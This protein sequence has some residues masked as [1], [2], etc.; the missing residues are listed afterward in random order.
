MA[1]CTSPS[2]SGLPRVSR[3][4]LPSS[5]V[6]LPDP[7]SR[8]AWDVVWQQ[9]SREALSQADCCFAGADLPVAPNSMTQTL[10]PSKHLR[11]SGEM[12][13]A[14]M[15]SLL[16]SAPYTYVTSYSSSLQ[17]QQSICVQRKGEDAVLCVLQ[18]K[19]RSCFCA[20]CCCL[21]LSMMC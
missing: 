6:V 8:F 18:L 2:P 17:Q 10:Y 7:A 4:L 20:S 5:V 19:K 13:R 1:K 15:S 11:M 12:L 14:C 21:L 16:A 9:H 3:P